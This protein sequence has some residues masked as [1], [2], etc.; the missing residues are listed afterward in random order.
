MSIYFNWL[1]TK[2]MLSVLSLLMLSMIPYGSVPMAARFSFSNE[3]TTIVVDPGHGGYD[4]GA[5][6]PSG[7]LEKTVALQ[8]AQMLQ[9]G[10]EDRYRV[11]IT[12]TTDYAVGTFERANFANHAKADLFI[13]IHTGGG[14]SP[15]EQRVHDFLFLTFL[16]T[17]HGQVGTTAVQ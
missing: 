1:T 5:Q 2:S 3:K 15:P 4:N 8:F 12:R 9:A 14:I 17:G 11:A 6:G 10:F 7:T 13:S 16:R